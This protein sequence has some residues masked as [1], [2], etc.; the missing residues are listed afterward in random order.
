MCTRTQARSLR[1]QGEFSFLFFLILLLILFIILIISICDRHHPA[2]EE[3]HKEN[4]SQAEQLR[5]LV[6][7]GV[8]KQEERGGEGLGA[9]EGKD[10]GDGEARGWAN[11][12]EVHM[13]RRSGETEDEEEEKRKLDKAKME[14]EEQEVKKLDEMIALREK[15]QE[16]RRLEEKEMGERKAKEEK[17][18][19]A[20]VDEENNSIPVTPVRKV[21]SRTSSFEVKITFL[22]FCT[23]SLQVIRSKTIILEE[24]NERMERTTMNITQTK[25]FSPMG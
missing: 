11:Q 14:E 8:A 9:L 16:R 22:L 21:L 1:C 17:K 6:E 7:G 23:F 4:R 3:E 2:N 25:V 10:E 15:E 24:T 13:V 5:T 19:E 18:E 20:K 12:E